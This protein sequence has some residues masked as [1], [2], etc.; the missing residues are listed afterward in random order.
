M[1][2]RK[3]IVEISADLVRR[4]DEL[5]GSKRRY[6]FI[7]TAVRRAL[8]SEAIRRFKELGDHFRGLTLEETYY[9]SRREL[10]ER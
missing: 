6:T 3:L 7:E 10:E 5:V 8:R 2:R 1:E 4:I 9:P